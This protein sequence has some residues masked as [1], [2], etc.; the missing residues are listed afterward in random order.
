MHYSIDA[1]FNNKKKIH[2]PNNSLCSKFWTM[3]K[4][5]GYVWKRFLMAVLRTNGKINKIS[6]VDVYFIANFDVEKV[7]NLNLFGFV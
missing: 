4:Y 1:T 6:F 2:V 3:N 5:N 7:L